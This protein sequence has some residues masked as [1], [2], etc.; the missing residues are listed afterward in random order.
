M[1]RGDYDDRDERPREDRDRRSPR[2]DPAQKVKAP[3][4]CLMVTAI[5]LLLMILFGAGWELSGMA[6]KQRQQQIQDIENDPNLQPQQK[7]DFV[8]LQQKLKDIFGPPNAYA[9]W[10]WTTGCAVLILVGAVKMKNLSSRGWAYTSAILAMIPCTSSICC[11]LG[12]PFG[13]WAL[14]ALNNPD[15]KRAFGRGRPDPRDDF[16]DRADRRRDEYDDRD[17]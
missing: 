2:V 17:R 13:I 10:A 1:S 4:I 7:K 12:L 8:E 9:S 11:L 3:A 5:L 6:E 14:I 15:V 16:D